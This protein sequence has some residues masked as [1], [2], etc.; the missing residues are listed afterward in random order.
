MRPDSVVLVAPI[1]ALADSIL[2]VRRAL[3]FAWFAV[4]IAPLSSLRPCTATSASVRLS[5]RNTKQLR[6][7][8]R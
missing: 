1:F 8:T 4:G 3:Q 2:W 5:S 7:V 6:L